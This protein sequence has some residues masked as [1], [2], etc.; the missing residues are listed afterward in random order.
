MQMNKQIECILPWNL[1]IFGLEPLRKQFLVMS[2]WT[3]IR[4][5]MIMVNRCSSCYMC[6]QIA[7]ISSSFLYVLSLQLPNLRVR[8]CRS[9][10]VFQSAYNIIENRFMP[11]LLD[12]FIFFQ[13]YK[14]EL[15]SKNYV[16]YL[17]VFYN[18][19]MG[20]HNVWCKTV[21]KCY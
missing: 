3:V 17:Q 13:F 11:N 4:L 7:S 14:I 21:P 9:L 12:I 10:I 19:R 5:A 2:F 1:K 20:L 16:G 6:L 8:L 15:V 18:I